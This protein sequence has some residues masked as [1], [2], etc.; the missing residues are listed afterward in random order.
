MSINLRALSPETYRALES[1]CA[2]RGWSPIYGYVE[3]EQ[4]AWLTFLLAETPD[5]DDTFPRGKW[6]TIQ[7]LQ[8]MVATAARAEI[9]DSAAEQGGEK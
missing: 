9:A 4:V 5:D 2:R 1:L 8:T 6:A 7:V 3:P